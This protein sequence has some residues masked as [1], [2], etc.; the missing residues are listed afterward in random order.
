MPHPVLPLLWAFPCHLET[1]FQTDFK[2]NTWCCGGYSS[3][4][5]MWNAQA[6]LQDSSMVLTVP[7]ERHLK[8][9]DTWALPEAFK[10]M[11]KEKKCSQPLRI[12]SVFMSH[13]FLP[14][15]SR[16]EAELCH[17]FPQTNGSCRL[18]RTVSKHC[19]PRFWTNQELA[20]CQIS[21]WRQETCLQRS[22]YPLNDKTLKEYATRNK[23]TYFSACSL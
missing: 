2:H 12:S 10:T 6:D 9:Y 11:L 5:N 3:G 21:N 18:Q 7:H 8:P 17:Q 16:Q 23:K 15:S 22:N 20:L 1:C 14:P 13:Y 19:R 4:R